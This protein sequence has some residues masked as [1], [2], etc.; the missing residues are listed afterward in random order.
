MDSN[1]YNSP[2]VEYGVDNIE[3]LNDIEWEEIL[4]NCP[5]LKQF[6]KVVIP[7]A[8]NRNEVI[9][10]TIFVGCDEL[11]KEGILQK[12]NDCSPT[13]IYTAS[14]PSAFEYKQGDLVA[15]LTSCSEQSLLILPGDLNKYPDNL[16]EIL[17][18]AINKN[19]L[20][21]IIG[22]GPAARSITIDLPVISVLFF[23]DTLLSRSDILSSTIQNV[24]DLRFLPKEIP[25]KIQLRK[26]IA[27][28]NLTIDEDAL[29]KLAYEAK[30]L[31]TP[32]RQILRPVIDCATFSDNPNIITVDIIEKALNTASDNAHFDKAT[33]LDSIDEYE[34]ERL[35]YS[36]FGKKNYN[37]VKVKNANEHGI[38]MIAEIDDFKI[39]IQII[40]AKSQVILP[41]VKDIVDDIK[42]MNLDKGYIITNRYFSNPAKALAAEN[43]ITMWD[44]STII[45]RFL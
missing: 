38:N 37:C 27:E 4:C 14:N 2:L 43:H 40:F 6:F 39:G 17:Q 34:F 3:I 21:V 22:K 44:K 30:V 1:N 31:S 20:N 15:Y 24:I 10:T 28:K 45:E 33:L 26:M 41:T 35:V 12:I 36:Y 16:R 42:L 9:G 7:A 5:A 8:I 29:I 19:T 11:L 32:P 18:E 13:T 23:S 25:L